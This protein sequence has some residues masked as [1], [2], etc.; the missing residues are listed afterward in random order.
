[1]EGFTMTLKNKQF[2][3]VRVATAVPKLRVADC[4]YNAGE[5]V[6]LMKEAQKLGVTVLVFPE[7]SLTGYTCAD[8]F[9]QDPLSGGAIAAL[10]TVKEA[11]RSDFDGLVLVGLPLEV[12]CQLFNCAAVLHRGRILGIVPKMFPPTY[13]EF[14]ESRWFRSAAS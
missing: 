2:G 5:H 10:Q 1:M 3:F 8:L 9:D 11:S 12:D 14:Y 6:A 7:L 13:K 4:S